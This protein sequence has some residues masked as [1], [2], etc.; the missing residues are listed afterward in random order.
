MTRLVSNNQPIANKDTALMTQTRG[1]TSESSGF[2]SI[3]MQISSADK[4]ESKMS[5][6]QKSSD[7]KIKQDSTETKFASKSEGLSDNPHE[8]IESE[9]MSE[10]ESEVVDEGEG[11]HISEEYLQQDPKNLS[12]TDILQLTTMLEQE[13]G[14]GKIITQL[15]QADLDIFDYTSPETE[16]LTSESLFSDEHREINQE[17]TDTTQPPSIERR[18][19]KDDSIIPEA[20]E[21]SPRIFSDEE[22]KLSQIPLQ[23]LKAKVKESKESDEPEKIYEDFAVAS[24]FEVSTEFKNTESKLRTADQKSV[25]TKDLADDNI[26]LESKSSTDTII[27]PEKFTQN[28]DNNNNPEFRKPDQ[29][30]IALKSEMEFEFKEPTKIEEKFTSE[31]SII[32]LARNSSEIKFTPSKPIITEVIKH[33]APV[34]EQ[35]SLTIHKAIS[36]GTERMQVVLRPETLGRVDIHVEI[37]SQTIREVKIFASKETLEFLVKDS[38]IL[39]QAIKEISKGSDVQLSFNMRGEGNDQDRE[40]QDAQ[41]NF[42]ADTE[43]SFYAVKSVDES[44][45]LSIISDDKVDITL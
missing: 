28:Q 14:E 41:N 15:S 26:L 3:F 10:R 5:F 17:T 11:K 18:D 21:E 22:N 9:S 1:Q 7:F 24:I 8:A 34:S 39:E 13:I 45:R 38:Q 32:D 40:F 37:Q 19:S 12:G 16:D 29:A 42:K 23:D 20:R 43:E 27:L 30:E 25:S 2:A 31:L 36:T 6:A 35:V 33:D 4:I 44:S